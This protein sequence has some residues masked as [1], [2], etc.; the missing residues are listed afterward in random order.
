ML[1]LLFWRE[2]LAFYLVPF[3]SFDIWFRTFVINGKHKRWTDWHGRLMLYVTSLILKRRYIKLHMPLNRHFPSICHSEVVLETWKL[4]CIFITYR[5]WNGTGSWIS[6]LWK[7]IS[8]LFRLIRAGDERS[9]GF[10]QV[11]Q[12]YSGSMTRSLKHFVALC[13]RRDT[14]FTQERLPATY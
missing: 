1:F 2:T 13:F 11:I 12:E 3:C 5:H 4:I 14:C 7:T 10:D 8:R 9:H 6:S